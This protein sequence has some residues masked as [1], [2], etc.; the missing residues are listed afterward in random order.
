MGGIICR[1]INRM[2]PSSS[3]RIL[4]VTGMHRSGTSA[5]CA[6][7]RA[8][9]ASFGS[10][11]LEPVAG[12]N[13]EGFWEDTDV[14]A[15]NE[16]LLEQLGSNWFTVDSS[17]LETDWGASRFD[18]ARC[19]GMDILKRGFGG[20]PL[21]ALKDPR[22]CITL[23]FW[24]MLCRQTG[25]PSSVCVI[26]RAP[27]EVARSLRNRDSFPLGYGLRLFQIYRL[28]LSRHAPQDTAFVTYDELLDNP[29]LTMQRLA[30]SLPLKV[31]PGKLNAVINGHLRHHTSEAKTG[32]LDQPDNGEID[33]EALNTLID[34]HYPGA[35]AMQDLVG[36]LV[37]RGQEL[38]RIGESHDLALSTIDQRDLQIREFDQRL[39]TLGKEHE[40]ALSTI[41][42][43]DQQIEEFDRR[44]SEIGAMHS[45]A[46]ATI[47]ERD[48]QIAEFEQRLSQL[49]E[50]LNHLLMTPVIGKMLKLMLK[51]EKS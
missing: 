25:V 4:F 10:R 31:V 14:V 34:Q 16:H 21:E 46:L 5:L 19:R 32:L 7:L 1:Q 2:A 13:D 27:L 24:L 12:V 3:R 30:N 45:T 49:S 20:G 23:P 6:A 29:E 18:K 8:C 26:G 38:S 40:Q 37:I 43:R 41:Q 28:G 17:D 51:N 48:R 22:L 39:S 11:L 9:G 42:V 35:H 47:D 36:Q 44:L 50:R 15:L 33:L